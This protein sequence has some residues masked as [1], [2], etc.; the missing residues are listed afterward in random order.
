MNETSKDESKNETFSGELF[1]PHSYGALQDVSSCPIHKL[2]QS[3]FSAF[4]AIGYLITNIFQYLKLIIN[5][6]DIIH[7]FNNMEI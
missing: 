7:N 1:Q 5:Q 4:S 6:P 2:Y 3:S